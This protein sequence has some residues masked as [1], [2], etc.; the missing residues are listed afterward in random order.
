MEDNSK[1]TKKLGR[2]ESDLKKVMHRCFQE[3][4]HPHG[5][6]HQ[7]NHAG[8]QRV[9]LCHRATGVSLGGMVSLPDSS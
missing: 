8:Q 9:P 6:N 4:I 3:L 2:K 1:Q 5:S 7:K